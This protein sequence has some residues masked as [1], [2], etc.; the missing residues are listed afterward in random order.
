MAAVLGVVA[1]LAVYLA[2]CATPFVIERIFGLGWGIAAGTAMSFF[3]L[4]K[5][6]STCRDGGFMCSVFGCQQFALLCYWLVRGA[7]A[8][9]AVVF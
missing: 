6:P 3:W 7:A 1:F 5:L 4:W 9:A 2:W 8:L